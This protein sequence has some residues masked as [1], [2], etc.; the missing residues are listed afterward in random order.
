MTAHTYGTY[1]HASMRE[2]QKEKTER[3]MF[4]NGEGLADLPA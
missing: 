3:T 1:I 2:R 4:P